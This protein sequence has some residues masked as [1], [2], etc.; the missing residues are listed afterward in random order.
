[1]KV[2]LT[3]QAAL[4]AVTLLLCLHARGLSEDVGITRM[5]TI[6]SNCDYIAVIHDTEELYDRFSQFDSEN[7][8]YGIGLYGTAIFVGTPQDSFSFSKGSTFCTLDVD[9]VIKGNIKTDS[10]DVE[11]KGGFHYETEAEFKERLMNAEDMEIETPSEKLFSLDFG[12]M[13]FMVPGKKYLIIAQTLDFKEKTVYR[14]NGYQ[15]SWLCLDETESKIMKEEYV[16]SECCNNEIFS[17]DHSIIEAFYAKK[18][19]ILKTYNI[20][21]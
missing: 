17:P 7:A 13:N 14:I 15:I 3:L 8:D 10:I 21:L 6:D 20:V 9:K 12:G 5:D 16:Y 11:I 4:I 2:F 18:D 1:M 19:D